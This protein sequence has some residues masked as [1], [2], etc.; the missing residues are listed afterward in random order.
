MNKLILGA[1]ALVSLTPVAI[2]ASSDYSWG[3]SQQ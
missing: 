1:I 2:F 3:M